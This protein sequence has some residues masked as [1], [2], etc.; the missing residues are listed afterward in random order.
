MLKINT[1]KLKILAAKVVAFFMRLFHIKFPT[2]GDQ[3]EKFV[4][5]QWEAG[6]RNFAPEIFAMT[7]E[8]REGWAITVVFDDK[9]GGKK[10]MRHLF[11]PNIEHVQE[12]KQE[13]LSVI[14]KYS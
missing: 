4:K 3:I 5:E 14:A 2:L 13:M 12:V 10:C 11:I 7:H 8:G 6:S 1:I 9:D